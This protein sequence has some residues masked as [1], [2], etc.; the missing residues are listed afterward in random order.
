MRP[1]A[2]LASTACVKPSI[3]RQDSHP[4]KK[5]GTQLVGR[6]GTM[7]QQTRQSHITPRIQGTLRKSIGRNG[8]LYRRSSS[9]PSNSTRAPEPEE[10][11]TH[12]LALDNEAIENLQSASDAPDSVAQSPLSLVSF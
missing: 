7:S 3:S 12:A 1:R 8:S 6:S 11:M 2:F 10:S 9:V 5:P 4:G